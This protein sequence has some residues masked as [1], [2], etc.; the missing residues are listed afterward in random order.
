MEYLYCVF[1]CRGRATKIIAAVVGVGSVS[2][3]VP[4]RTTFA[5]NGDYNQWKKVCKDDEPKKLL[6]VTF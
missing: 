3:Y 1:F 4:L 5:W 6:I 2:V